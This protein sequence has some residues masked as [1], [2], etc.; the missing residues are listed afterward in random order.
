MALTDAGKKF[1]MENDMRTANMWVGLSTA[2]TDTIVEASNQGYA[3]VAVPAAANNR[4]ISA[5]GVMTLAAS[6]VPLVVYTPTDGNAPDHARGAL[7]DAASAGNRLTDWET[8]SPDID[9]P[10]QNQAY[11]LTQLTLTP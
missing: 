11:R 9:A 4:S 10:V 2:A 5:A 6:V 3:R 7:F 1:V 8:P